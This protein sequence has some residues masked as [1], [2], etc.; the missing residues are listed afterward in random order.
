MEWIEVIV[1]VGVFGMLIS[2]GVPISFCIGIATAVTMLVTIMPMPAVTTVAQRMATGLD[3]FALLAIPFFILS[4]QL[5]NRGGIARRLIEFAKVLVGM[6]P[7]GLAFVN[8]MANMLFGSISGSAVAAASA[9]GGFMTP[10]MD[11]EGYDRDFS[12]AVNISSATTGLLIPPSNVLIVYS[13]A[14]GGVSIAA[15]F[16]AGYIPGI[17]LGIMLMSVAAVIAIRRKYP[18]GGFVPVREALLKLFDAVPSLLLVVIVMG[19]IVLGYFTA[20]EASAI[21]VLY[22]FVLSVIVYRE[23]K[24]SELPGILLSAASTTAIVMLLIGTSMGMSWILAYTNIPQNVSAALLG[25]TDNKIMILLIINLILLTVGT[26]MDMTPAVL[27]FTPIFLPVA[28]GL[29]IDPVHFGIIIVFNLCIGLCTPPVG[30]VLFVG[31]GIAN[32]TIA[33]IIRPLMPMFLAMIVSLLI[34]T[35][36]PDISLF[37]PRLF[38]F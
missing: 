8:I 32:I 23:V 26:F 16:L 1:L 13:L 11:K 22:T 28:V 30:S 19:G 6:L 3:S 2:A 33:K 35:Y 12:A 24:V 5:M 18:V 36:V 31:A 34:V 38:G 9:I 7:G 14:S 27:I 4:G 10:L 21:A 15:L 29:G 37:V 17:L 25:L 20:T